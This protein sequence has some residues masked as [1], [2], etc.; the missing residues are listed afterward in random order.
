MSLIVNKFEHVWEAEVSLYGKVDR[1]GKGAP[2]WTA[3]TGLGDGHIGIPTLW[4]DRQTQLKTLPLPLYWGK[5]F[6]HLTEA[7]LPQKQKS[8]FLY[9]MRL[10]ISRVTLA[11]MYIKVWK[12]RLSISKRSIKKKI[13]CRK[14]PIFIVYFGKFLW[15]KYCWIERVGPQ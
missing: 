4:T 11:P 13:H 2:K 9:W 7:Y 1:P 12:S 10:V 3:W 5:I 15:K 14:I 8:M 6:Y